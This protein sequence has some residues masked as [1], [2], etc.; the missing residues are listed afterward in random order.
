LI[1]HEFCPTLQEFTY[2]QLG[3]KKSEVPWQENLFYTHLLSIPV[4]ALVGPDI[5]THAAIL[6][7]CDVMPLPSMGLIVP[8]PWVYLFL[9]VV[10]QYICV[11]GVYMMVGTTDNLT[12]ALVLSIR[13]LLSL[14]ISIYTF[15]HPFTTLHGLGVALVIIGSFT[16]TREQIA[17]R[18][19]PPA[20]SE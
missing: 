3:L 5:A 6:N 1:D 13:K 18:E 15:Q 7:K 17:Q 16:Y 4:F 8:L 19:K 14:V 12:C 2:E 9:N 20:K 11:R 10:T